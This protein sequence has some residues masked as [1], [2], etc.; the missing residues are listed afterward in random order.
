MQKHI[1]VTG[2]S[3]F[4]GGQTVLHL[5]DQGHLVTAVD[6]KL[7]P[8]HLKGI[9]DNT[10]IDTFDSP[11]VLDFL[12]RQSA[13]V[14][15]HCGA[16]SL[17]GPSIKNPR[18]Y[19]ENNTISTKTLLD[20][21]VDHAPHTRLI[22]SSSSSVY[23]EPVL[24]PI[25][26]SDPALPLSPYGESKLM[27]D[28]ML[29][30][31]Q[32]AY[33]LDYVSFRYFNA[34]GADPKGRHGQAPKATHII[35]RILES[36]RDDVEFTLNGNDYAT[37]D[38][39][40]VRDHVHVS[41][42]AAAHALAV[43]RAFKSGVY[44]IGIGHGS[45]N[46]EVIDAAEKITG[47]TLRLKTGPRREG[48]PAQLLADNSRLKAQGWHPQYDLHHMISHAWNWYQRCA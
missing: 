45:S 7:T 48:D 11:R 40:C 5:K 23:G 39:S 8:E 1:M 4:V 16:T 44:N 21:L 42:V 18:Q 15:I 28:M 43:D 27:T 33:G 10:I 38:G 14:I 31:Y 13:D 24:I 46:L 41:D 9:A 6:V 35:A 34:V 32:R 2:S 30:N 22:F 12:N 17:V 47:K 37:T 26:E 3:G 20:F 29:A 19:Y 25:S 36:I